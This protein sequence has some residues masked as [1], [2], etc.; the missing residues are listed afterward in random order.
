MLLFSCTLLLSIIS[1]EKWLDYVD[2]YC[3]LLLVDY[4]RNSE[5]HV[6]VVRLSF[7]MLKLCF[8]IMVVGKKL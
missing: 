2:T 8:G 4:W 6:S 3:A 1:K 5:K 7:F